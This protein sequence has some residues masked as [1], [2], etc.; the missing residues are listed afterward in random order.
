MCTSGA[1]SAVYPSGEPFILLAK[2]MDF[3]I[4]P[5]WHG[6]C[7]LQNGYRCLA[8]G[9][10]GQIGINSGLNEKGLGV[11]LSYLGCYVPEEKEEEQTK[12]QKWGEDERGL[13][14]AEILTRCSNVEEA[15]EY[16]Y[17]FIKRRP[18]IPGGN[19]MLVDAT[20]KIAV[21]EH[22]LGSANHKFY[23]EGYT[24]RGN[25]GLLILEDE[26]TNLPERIKFDRSSRYERMNKVMFS[27][28]DSVING[29][30]TRTEAIE[31]VKETLSYHN[32]EGK[33]KPGTICTHGLILPGG[34]T[35]LSKANWTI[36]AAIFDVV[37][38]EMFYTY[39][40]PCES[41]WQKLSLTN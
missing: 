19:H 41:E 34:R 7:Y 38:K 25:N 35:S 39:G 3:P 20:G 11:V 22:G 8:F 26:Q 23:E 16:L 36:T 6:I 10:T 29:R 24:A 9:M 2:T 40:P 27:I 12:F 5:C 13:A 31:E 30:I 17:D 37:N 14:N 33:E 1:V 15:V 4:S 21:F 28:R 18:N 32:P